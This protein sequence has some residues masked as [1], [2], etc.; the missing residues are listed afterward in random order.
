[1]PSLHRPPVLIA[2]RKTSNLRFSKIVSKVALS[3]SAPSRLI[4]PKNGL[5]NINDLLLMLSAKGNG[6][7]QNGSFSPVSSVFDTRALVRL[8]SGQL[9]ISQFGQPRAAAAVDKGGGSFP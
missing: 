9:G 3:G 5:K 7:R 4:G 1:M 2:I 8:W 6:P